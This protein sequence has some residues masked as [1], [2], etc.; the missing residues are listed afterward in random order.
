MDVLTLDQQ[1]SQ[2]PFFSQLSSQALAQVVSDLQQ[3]APPQ[4]PPQQNMRLVQLP[5]LSVSTAPSLSQASP[6]SQT[7]TTVAIDINS[8]SLGPETFLI[9]PLTLGSAGFS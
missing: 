3:R 1:L 6:S 8:V 2:Y 7:P 4:Q 9:S 5:P